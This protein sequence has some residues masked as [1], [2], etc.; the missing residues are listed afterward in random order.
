MCSSTFFPSLRTPTSRAAHRTVH[1]GQGA[2]MGG[3]DKWCS[4]G[5][6]LLN[7]SKLLLVQALL[8]DNILLLLQLLLRPLQ[9]PIVV[10]LPLSSSCIDEWWKFLSF[11]EQIELQANLLH[12]FSSWSTAYPTCC[13]N[14][15]ISFKAQ[16]SKLECF[17]PLKTRQKRLAVSDVRA[18]IFESQNSFLTLSPQRR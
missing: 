14:F 5:I 17:F 11:I 2:T 9:R 8:F 10:L 6:R 16:N 7:G 1:G 4:R 18:F 3:R 15:K 12:Y 13:D